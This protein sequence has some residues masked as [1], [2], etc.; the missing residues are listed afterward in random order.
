MT[1][2]LP[3]CNPVLLEPIM[4]VMIHV[5][6]E[7]TGQINGVISTRR[8]QVLG[9]DAREGWS[10]WDTVNANLPQSE[11][12]DL[13]IELRSLTQGTGTFR[14]EFDHVSELTGR[15]ADQVLQQYGRQA[16]KE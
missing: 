12:A 16:E 7:Y 8:G 2:G 11:M 6:S 10:G 13:I 4:K 3:G 1:E 5:P 9:F 14:Y 15:L